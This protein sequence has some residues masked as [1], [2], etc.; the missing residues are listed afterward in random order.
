MFG[1]TPVEGLTEG[2]GTD[3]REREREREREKDA[4]AAAAAEAFLIQDVRRLDLEALGSFLDLWNI[5]RSR[6]LPICIVLSSEM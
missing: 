1:R 3:E 4:S 5:N 6:I 2:G